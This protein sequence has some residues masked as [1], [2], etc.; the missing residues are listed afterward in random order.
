M[1][2][3]EVIHYLIGMVIVFFLVWV[4][5]YLNNYFSK[6]NIPITSQTLTEQFVGHQVNLSP[7]KKSVY[8]HS[9]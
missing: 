3:S 4:I 8:F 1:S 2:L 7:A 6:N 9:K 5:I